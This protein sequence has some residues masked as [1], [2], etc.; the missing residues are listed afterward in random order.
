LK[1]F[2]NFWTTK[3]SFHL[4]PCGSQYDNNNNHAC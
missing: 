1:I 3:I 4:K 2:S